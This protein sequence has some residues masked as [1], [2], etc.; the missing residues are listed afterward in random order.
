MLCGRPPALAC[1]LG[2]IICGSILPLTISRYS[3]LQL[4]LYSLAFSTRPPSFSVHYFTMSSLK[5]FEL[6]L[7]SSAFSARPPPFSVH[8]FQDVLD[9]V[10]SSS[11]LFPA[12]PFKT[13]A[14]FP[15][16]TSQST[17]SPESPQAHLHFQTHIPSPTQPPPPSPRTSQTTPPA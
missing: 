11:S 7:Y 4:V 9:K 5:S 17:S 14:F 2:C 15:S 6:I 8:L 1:H 3:H 10:L 12:F 13:I 16:P